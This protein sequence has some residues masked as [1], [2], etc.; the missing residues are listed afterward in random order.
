MKQT[1]ITIAFFLAFGLTTAFANDGT[2]LSPKISNAFNKEFANAQN[3]NWQKKDAYIIANFTLNNQV[4]YAYYLQNGQLDIIVHNILSD[5]LPVLLLAQLKNNYTGYWISEL[6]EAVNN[7]HSS[8]YITLENADQKIML[9]S[10]FAKE[11]DITKIIS[12]DCQ[13]L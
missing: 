1:I 8:Y 7:G 11:W 12:K 4:L 5:N 2:P 3:I 6:Y 10:E 13:Q 9:K